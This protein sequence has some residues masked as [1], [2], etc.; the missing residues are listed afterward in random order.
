MHLR[1]GDTNILLQSDDERIRASW[2]IIFANALKHEA[3][4][5]AQIQLSL[6]LRLA[7]ALSVPPPAYC[8][9]RD[10]QKIVDVYRRED[11]AFALHFLQGALVYVA[12]D[13]EEVARG[14]VTFAVSN[15]EQLEDVTYT[16][17]AP[18]LRRR[19]RYLLHAAAASTARGVVLL[20]GPTH[21]GK[22]TTELALVLAGWQ[23]LAG[24]VVLLSERDAGLLA[25]P[26]PGLLGAR[27]KS[28]QLL[29]DLLSLLPE[30][31]VTAPIGNAR[32]LVL[33]AER[34]GRA[35][36]VVAICFP[37][38]NGDRHSTLHPLPASVMLARL[39]EQSVD[40]WDS[41]SLPQ[42]MAFLER[43]CLQA[44]GY[45]L[46]LAP[47]VERLPQLLAAIP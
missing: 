18:L 24:D 28:F 37:E 46:A 34:W 33:P 26:T 19:D 3:R 45:R 21:S 32:R 43:L 17:L 27:S 22:T 9:Y 25:H 7:S 13:R 10:P 35:D 15:S 4:D 8:I 20:V 38:L 6:Q 16:A 14:Q 23:H 40:R 29:P 5:A 42:H 11:D 44:R 36:P 2:R 41:G 12:P 1:L 31:D 47:D 39:M 30:T